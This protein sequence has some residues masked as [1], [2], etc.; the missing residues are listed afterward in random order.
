VTGD[1]AELLAQAVALHR[2]GR[3]DDAQAAYREVLVLQPQQLDALHLRGA[4]LRDLGRAAEALVCIDAA[5]AIDAA[6]A[7]AWANRAAA[8]LDLGRAQEALDAV[9][10]SLALDPN[11][12]AARYNRA[13]ALERLGRHPDALAASDHALERLPDHPD[14]LDRR[15]RLL[16]ALGRPQDAL[17]SHA[18]AVAL[19]PEDAGLHVNHGHALADLGRHEEAAQA[20]ARAWALAPELP[21]LLGHLLHARLKTCDWGGLEALFGQLAAAVDASRPACEPFVTLFT[22][23]SAA[24]QRRCAE[25]HVRHAWPDHADVPRAASRDAA[26]IH[27]GYFSADF[28]DHPTARLIAGVLERHDRRRVEV[29]AFAFGAP[30]DDGMRMRL[31]AGVDRFIDVHERSDDEI[32]ALAR[33]LG[34]QIAIDLG[35]HTRGARGGVFA[36]R[37]APLQVAW[38]GYP[39]TFGAPFIDYLIADPVVLPPGQTSAYTEHI[40]WLPHCYQPN[41]DRRAMAEREVTRR[42]HGLPDEGFVFCCFNQA[43]KIG[44]QVFEVWMG[45]LRAVPDSVLWLLQGGPAVSDRLRKEAGARGV[46]PQRLVFAPRVAPAEHLVRHRVADLFIDTWP[47]NAHTTASDALW[48]GVPVLT[49]IGETFAAR[50]GASLL[51]AIGLPELTTHSTADYA[52]LAVAL[53]TNPPR[54]AALRT[55]LAA[56]RSTAPLFDTL[57]FTRDLEAAYAAMWARHAGGEPPASFAVPS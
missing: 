35:G 36:R 44:P 25:I 17:A 30:T 46:A 48:A 12:A 13:S 15:G 37:A 51:N 34:V 52:A 39:G 20:Y 57:R 8:L 26:R 6:H 38:L 5:L 45:L 3:L 10:R 55:R 33:E 11:D 4:A 18:R 7:K 53:A 16:R 28:R 27:L 1:P 56:Q 54:L 31:H 32:V 49:C 29:T 14:L 9:D 23:L 47:C 24:Q 50:V 2:A 40:A 19:A 43:A 42:A 22:P 21:Y 41:D